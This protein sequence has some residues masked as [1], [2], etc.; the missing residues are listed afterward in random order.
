MTVLEEIIT[1]KK[2]EV[3]DLR[4]QVPLRKLEQS[5]YFEREVLSLTNHLADSA[6][7]AIVAE[8]K[9]KSPSKGMINEH[10]VPEEITKGY[11]DGGAS[12]IS[13]LTDHRFFGGSPE[14]LIRAR[15]AISIPLLRKDFTID[16]Y[17]VIESKAMGA[18]A[19]LL[20]ASCLSY[21]Q[22]KNLARTAKSLKLQVVLEVH[23]LPELSLINEY[24]DIVGV[25]N[26]DLK[27]FKVDIHT[28]VE[29]ISGIPSGFVKISESGIS[30]VENLKKLKE[31]G[32]DG[33]LIGEFF[34]KE[35]DPVKAFFEF[36]R[37]LK[38]ND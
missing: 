19:I 10:A 1:F 26:R 6:K 30:N 7:T 27:T 29:I 33:F 15:K 4:N 3:K 31:I 18:D 28:S 20:I 38:A 32:Y 12:G 13:V 8:F 17:Q 37:K 36:V 25:N 24:I 34:M 2:A 35:N 21:Q 11:A 5:E 23:N 22:L 14:D 16:E 9:R